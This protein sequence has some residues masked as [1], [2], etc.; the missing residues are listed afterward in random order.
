VLTPTGG[1]EFSLRWMALA[2]PPQ[3]QKQRI[4]NYLRVFGPSVRLDTVTMTDPHDL[5]QPLVIK[6]HFTVPDFATVLKSKPGDRKSTIR[7]TLPRAGNGMLTSSVLCWA[8]SMPARK[9]DVDFHSTLAWHMVHKTTLPRGFR[10]VLV[11][12]SLTQTFDKFEA[13]STTRAKGRLLTNEAWFRLKAPLVPVAEY[14]DLRN[15]L[16]AA[17]ELERQHVMLKTVEE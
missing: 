10:T 7:F 17:E 6:L 3:Q 11:P 12:D 1:Q 5:N 15:L 14:Q 9:Y 16:A 4:E 2:L 8:S 13:N